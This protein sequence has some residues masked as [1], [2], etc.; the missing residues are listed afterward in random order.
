M[1]KIAVTAIA[2]LFFF[3]SKAQVDSSNNM[4]DLN[5]K[6]FNIYRAWISL[7]NDP[8]PLKGVLYEIN[9]SSILVSNSVLREDYYT[10][11]FELSKIKFND[12]DIV[13]TRLK[14]N[15]VKVA[16]IGAATGFIAGGLT[17][18][19]SGD[20]PPGLFSFS[21]EEKAL[22]FGCGIAAVGAGAGALE[23]LVKIKIPING[24]IDNFNRNKN[25]LKK[26][27]IRKK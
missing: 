23:G 13:S 24:N 26:Y 17:G 21:A 11:R 7:I 6:S 22:L 9:D 4:S 16:L 12:I 20:D 1:R 19:I 5:E 15:F 27:S 8:I 14:N 18:L 2:M 10:G 3:V 25:K